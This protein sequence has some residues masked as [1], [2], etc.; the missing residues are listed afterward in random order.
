MIANTNRFLMAPQDYLAW[1]EQQQWKHEYLNG[2]AYAMVGGTLN[3]NAVALNLASALKSHLRGSDCRVFINDVMVQAH[4]DMAYYYPDLVVTCN[5]T[6][7]KAKRLVQ[8][9]CLIIEVLSPD[10]EGYDRG[11]KFKQYRQLSSLKE[12]VLV[13]A[14]SKG[15]ECYRLNTQ[16]KWELNTYFPEQGAENATVEFASVGFT[17]SLDLVYEDIEIDESTS[18]SPRN[19]AL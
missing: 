10:T 8:S 13:N 9:P 19:E 14:E 17:C 5:P 6:D 18:R 15:V 11:E 3:H 16:G 1:E 4:K 2:E 12:Y 7:L